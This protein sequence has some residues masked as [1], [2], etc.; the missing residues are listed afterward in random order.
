MVAERHRAMNLGRYLLLAA[1][2]SISVG[3]GCSSHRSPTDAA[4]LAGGE[5]EPLQPG[6]A[7][8]IR[9][10]RETELGGTFRVDEFGMVVLPLLGERT[11]QGLS[12]P[13]LRREI[14]SEYE[15]Q[16]RNQA[17]EVT[18][19]RRIRILGEVR[20]PGLI[21]VDATMSL[22]DAIALAGG[23]TNLG[24][25]KHV[26][27]V[28]GGE[29]VASGLDVTHPVTAGVHSGDQVYVPMRSWV[30]RN[31]TMLVGVLISSA[32]SIAVWGFLR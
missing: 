9:F 11:V 30:S 27:L 14:R 31:S 4:L 20:N 10:S 24:D 2:V 8:R 32:A 23:A 22:D 29:E 25:L 17:V 19:L 12:P 15:V 7:V 26:S 5:P 3:T 13:L 1:V 28:R 6:D 18:P 21:D 16:L